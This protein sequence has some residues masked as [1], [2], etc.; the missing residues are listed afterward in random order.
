MC[1]CIEDYF[2]ELSV[3]YPRVSSRNHFLN[4]CVRVCECVCVCSERARAS[5]RVT[6]HRDCSRS[7]GSLELVSESLKRGVV[8]VA[9]L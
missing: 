1:V 3:Q 2:D 9:S 4:L 7:V 5:V 8:S 6:V